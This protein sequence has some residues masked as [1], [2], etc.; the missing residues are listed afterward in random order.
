MATN[1]PSPGERIR[2]T[3]RRLAPLPGGKTLFSHLIGWMAPYSNTIH[4][5][6]LEL[7]P[8]YAKLAMRDRHGVRNHLNSVHAVALANLAE[9]SSGLAMLAGLPATARGIPIGLA[10]TYVKKARGPLTAECRCTL[11]DFSRETEFEVTARIADAG[12]DVVATATVRWKLGPI[13]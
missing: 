6:V 3:W 12:G 1:V 9:L 13:P 5:R 10:V 4:A 7:E 2:G 8:G 11:P